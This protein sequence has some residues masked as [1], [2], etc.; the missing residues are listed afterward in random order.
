MGFAV[1]DYSHRKIALHHDNAKNLT[2]D[3][4]ISKSVGN[5]A[6]GPIW[7]QLAQPFTL[8]CVREKLSGALSEAFE[9]AILQGLERGDRAYRGIGR[10]E[11]DLDVV[12]FSSR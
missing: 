9:N 6:A 10:R 7:A 5:A 12:V 3:I 8:S 11:A 4:R 1:L 2:L